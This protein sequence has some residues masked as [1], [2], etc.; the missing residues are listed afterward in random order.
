M[1]A[2]R[3]KLGRG[4]SGLIQLESPVVVP[5]APTEEELRTNPPVAGGMSPSGASSPVSGGAE[6]PVSVVGGV[7]FQRLPVGLLKPNPFQPR[8]EMGEAQ[9]AELAESIKQSGVIQPVIVRRVG[10]GYELVAGERRW[11]AS[12][13]AGLETIPAVVRNLSD[14]ESAEIA[15]V[16]NIH[17]E[18]L[19]PM[20]RAWGLRNFCD[21]FRLSHSEVGERTGLDRSSVANFLR[22]TELEAEVQELLRTGKLSL[23]H[24]KML[25][26]V[27]AGPTRVGL[28]Q[29]AAMGK[30]TLK[31]MEDSIKSMAKRGQVVG[32]VK[33]A[34]I[35]DL[36]KQLSTWLG[37]RVEIVTRKDGQEGKIEIE[38]YSLD[39]F[40]GMMTKMGF[41]PEG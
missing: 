4:L 9:L 18:D 30:W 20:D 2:P 14:V 12:Q 38:F 33:P 35:A 1:D 8:R 10:T 22:L 29:S 5:I 21:K 15:L 25:L 19:N 3:R 28:A 13:L 32:K 31:R 7:E 26:G 11:R 6:A 41:R 39:H 23:A 40:D 37:T 17:R 36:E 24:G 16:E 27:S 34:A